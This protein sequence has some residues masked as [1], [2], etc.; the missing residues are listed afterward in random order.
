MTKNSRFSPDICVIDTIIIL[1]QNAALIT[2]LY[3]HTDLNMINFRREVCLTSTSNKAI[4]TH[5]EI[6]CILRYKTTQFC[7]SSQGSARIC[8]LH[9][10]SFAEF[11]LFN[12]GLSETEIC[13][14]TEFQEPCR[15]KDITRTFL[16]ASDR[17]VVVSVRTDTPI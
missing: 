8:Y 14:L 2:T 17:H 15:S 12:V 11:M 13:F 16:V 3:Y 10:D 7:R 9:P 5:S 4:G 6:C 1:L